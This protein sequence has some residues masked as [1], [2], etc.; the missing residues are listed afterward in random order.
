MKDGFVDLISMCHFSIP[1]GS[2]SYERT[3]RAI[4][5]CASTARLRCGSRRDRRDEPLWTSSFDGA[6][7]S[8]DH[9]SQ[10]R[11]W[12]PAPEPQTHRAS[13]VLP[14]IY[15]SLTCK[16]SDISAKPQ[17]LTCIA[18]RRQNTRQDPRQERASTSSAR[19]SRI[20]PKILATCAL[21]RGRQADMHAAPSISHVD[22]HNRVN[23]R[24]ARPNSRSA[25]SAQTT[26]PRKFGNRFTRSGERYFSSS[27]VTATLAFAESRTLLPSTSATRL[28]G[29]K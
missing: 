29:T 2:L 7:P 16:Y 19:Q 10:C 4:H 14:P 15:Q 8:L 27:N 26:C 3:R 1:L 18:C 11:T 13:L 21:R 5:P 24:D 23:G 12:R 25:R 22:R 20:Q 17:N 9:R 28:R 6:K